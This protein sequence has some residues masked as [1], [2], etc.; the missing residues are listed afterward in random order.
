MRHTESLEI[1]YA[2]KTNIKKMFD[3]CEEN[4]VVVRENM[5]DERNQR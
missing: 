2:E 5:H 3:L 1:A 4:E